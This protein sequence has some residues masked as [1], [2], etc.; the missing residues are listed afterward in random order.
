MG[1]QEFTLFAMLAAVIVCMFAVIF[2]VRRLK[3]KQDKKTVQLDK[4]TEAID[5]S[6]I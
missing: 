1:E 2:I 3:V 5:S 4:I 6:K